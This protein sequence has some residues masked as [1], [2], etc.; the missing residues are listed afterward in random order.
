[1]C[2]LAHEAWPIYEAHVLST[3][4]PPSRV[5]VIHCIISSY[6]ITCRRWLHGMDQ[7]GFEI[8]LE[9]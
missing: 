4:I 8:L 9:L 7:K 2:V 6:K 3:Y 1:M 5:R